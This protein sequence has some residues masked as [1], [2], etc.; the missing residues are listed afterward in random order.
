MIIRNVYKLA[1][2]EMDSMDDFTDSENGTDTDNAPYTET[3]TVHGSGTVTSLNY[4]TAA[5]DC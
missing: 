1:K 4:D 3:C 2:E 5:D